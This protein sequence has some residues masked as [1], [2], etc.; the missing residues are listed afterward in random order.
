MVGVNYRDFDETERINKELVKLNGEFT[1]SPESQRNLA[2]FVAERNRL[3]EQLQLVRIRISP[4]A[5][6][7][8]NVQ[9]VVY[10]NA[11]I[12]LGQNFKLIREEIQG[13]VS[14]IPNT[15]EGGL[16][17]LEMT[18]LSVPAEELEQSVILEEAMRESS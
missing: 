13:P 11:R 18:P 1:A 9:R 7:R 3:S 2:A 17:E 16:R 10:E 5:N 12:T 8:I 6:P 14:L 4:E 15:V